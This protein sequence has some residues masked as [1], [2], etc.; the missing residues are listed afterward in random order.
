MTNRRQFIQHGVVLSAVPLVLNQAYAQAPPMRMTP[1]LAGF[2]DRYSESRLFASV[3]MYHGVPV[4]AIQGDVTALWYDD[5][6]HRWAAA[7]SPIVGLTGASS[8]FCLEHLAWKVERRVMFR[9]VHSQQAELIEHELTGPEPLAAAAASLQ[10]ERRWPLWSA[11]VAQ[12]LPAVLKRGSRFQA[13]ATGKGLSP[14]D[15]WGGESLVT[16]AITLKPTV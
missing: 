8:L 3:L 4:H 6:Y 16:W 7:P 12:G 1:S 15:A 11:S 10:A 9:A 2:D 14:A 13:R 5:L